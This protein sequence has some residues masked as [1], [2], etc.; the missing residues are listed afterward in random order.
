MFG[1]GRKSKMSSNDR[2]VMAKGKEAGN[3]GNH[4][5]SGDGKHGKETPN[6]FEPRTLK[7]GG[8]NRFRKSDF[9]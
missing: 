7:V 5:G 6:P 9:E 8:N 4:K 1:K 2:F 3:F